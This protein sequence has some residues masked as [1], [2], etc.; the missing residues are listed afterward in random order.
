MTELAILVNANAKRGGRRV[1]AQLAKRVPGASVKLSRSVAEIDVWLR[2]LNNPACV[3]AAGGDGTQISLLSA[4]Q[5]VFGHVDN[6]PLVGALPLGTG[7]AWAHALGARKLD[8]CVRALR[9]HVGTLPVRRYGLFECEG[10]LTFMAGSGW[11]AQVL[12]DYRV[13]MR[14]AKGPLRPLSKTVYGYVSAMLLRTAPKTVL[15]A[16]PRVRI[17]NLS[18]EAFTIGPDRV[19]RKLHNIGRNSVLYDGFASVVGAATCPE[20]G[21]RFKAFPM[22]ERFPGMMNVRV[23]DQSAAAAIWD[24][25]KLWRGAHPLDG[26]NDWF[27]SHVRLTFSRPAPLQIAGEAIGM[28][29]TI[30]YKSLP[31]MMRVLDWRAFL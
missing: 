22:A 24:I 29:E 12:E 23:Y 8:G 19:P 25:P 26:M 15:Q 6:W 1:A 14:D 20:Y 11:D 10:H 17:E 28:R 9:A 30:E 21:F 7:N 2:T 5:R 13:Q 18:D 31:G 3:F 16:R 4:M 27:S